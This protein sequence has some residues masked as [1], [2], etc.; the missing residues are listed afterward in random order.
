M[1]VAQSLADF[2]AS[3]TQCNSLIANAHRQ[4][5]NGNHLFPQQDREQIT[6]AAFLN[7]FIAWEG[8]LEAAIG[9]FMMG[10]TTLN[11][12]QPVKYVSPPTRPHSTGMVIHTHRYF[13]FAHHDNVRKLMKLYFE[14]GYPFEGPIVSINAELFDLKTIRNS[15]AHISSST[16]TALTGLAVRIF[17]QPQPNIT[18]YQ[19]LTAI[20]PREAG[21]NTTVC[22]LPSQA[23]S[24]SNAHR[25]GLSFEHCTGLLQQLPFSSEAGF[26]AFRAFVGRVAKREARLRGVVVEAQWDGV[27]V[28]S[29]LPHPLPGADMVHFDWPGAAVDAGAGVRASLL[30][31]LPLRFLLGHARP[32]GASP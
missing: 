18:V 8:F 5:A 15:C 20:D 6:V 9:D 3:L 22:R 2:N 29:P 28:A 11:G 26:K 10:E 4:D 14:N 32:I 23:R 16:Q 12:A 1:P 17:G 24:S 21:N 7:M 30:E 31:F 25:H 19:M 27:E 13:D